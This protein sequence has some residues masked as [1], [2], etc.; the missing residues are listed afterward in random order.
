MN[1]Q[2]EVESG[3]ST[4]SNDQVKKEVEHAVASI[5]A[6]PTGD[7]LKKFDIMNL[8]NGR[9]CRR[10]N[11]YF[12]LVMIALSIVI[13]FIFGDGIIASILGL[14]VGALGITVTVR[15]LHDLD[16]SGWYAL[17]PVVLAVFS[18]GGAMFG[19][20]S[21]LGGMRGGMGFGFGLSG[22]ASLVSIAFS[23]YL[24]FKRGNQEPNMYGQVPVS[25]APLWKSILNV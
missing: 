8:F 15:R 21:A 2:H 10:H 9:I 17:V 24:I 1:E 18:A 7:E 16:L 5:K 25:T 14:V 13:N 22:L 23:L 4:A 19:G 6:V 11:A 3:Q 20:M 12:I